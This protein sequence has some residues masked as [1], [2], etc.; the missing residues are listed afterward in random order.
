MLIFS[1]RGR[2]WDGCI[3]YDDLPRLIN[4]YW[5]K[6]F[7]FWPMAI[8]DCDRRL[9]RYIFLLNFLRMAL[10]RIN[11]WTFVSYRIVLKIVFSQKNRTT[12]DLWHICLNNHLFFFSLNFVFAF[13]KLD[14]IFF[15]AIFCKLI[16]F[17]FCCSFIF[18]F[19]FLQSIFFP[20]C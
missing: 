19:W 4:K 6:T 13:H 14:I 11:D 8:G 15:S 12:M 3:N 16:R 7:V 17:F 5:Y 18:C 20:L 2:K 9:L 1:R 10:L